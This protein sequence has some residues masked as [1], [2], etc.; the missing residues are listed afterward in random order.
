M[1]AFF[2]SLVA[3]GIML[4]ICGYVAWRR[5]IGQPTTWGEAMSGATFVF[6]ILLLMFGIVPDQ[7]IDWADNELGWSREVFL[8]DWTTH[9]FLGSFL[10][11]NIHM[12]AVRDVVVIIIHVVFLVMI[13]PMVM[14]W[15]RRGPAR[16]LG[17][18]SIEVP[19]S[20]FGRP[21]VRES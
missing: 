1:I 13:P 21:L 3:V 19:V 10:K 7:F 14:M 6:M 11:I 4:G 2:M 18:P 8:Y 16:S 9:E 12:E 15:Q 20:D 5:P 17:E